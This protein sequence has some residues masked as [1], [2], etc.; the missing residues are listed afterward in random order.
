MGYQ[1]ST[2]LSSIANPPRAVYG[3]NMWGKRSTTVVSS[4]TLVGQNVWL[5]NTTDGSTDLVSTAYFT[6]AQQ[7]GMRDGDIVMGA[8][9][10]SGTSITFYA[11][12][13][14]P[15]TTAGAGFNS[16]NAYVSSTR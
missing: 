2:Q 16:T 9:T 15:V 13:L 12:A 5:Y 3:A 4:T 1:G 11:G 7:L 8:I 14:G 6:D 10:N